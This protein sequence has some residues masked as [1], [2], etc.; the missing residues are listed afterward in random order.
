MTNELNRRKVEQDFTWVDPTSG[1]FDDTLGDM[2]WLQTEKT[3]LFGG[4]FGRKFE[5]VAASVLGRAKG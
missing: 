4:L 5:D 2:I 3:G 1:P